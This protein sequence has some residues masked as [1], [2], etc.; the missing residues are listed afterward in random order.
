MEPDARLELSV[1]WSCPIPPGA[2]RGN[3]KVTVPVK[4]S[5]GC[6]EYLCNEPAGA[7]R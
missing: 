7:W 1:E 6:G 3:N 5:V 2:Q 4:M